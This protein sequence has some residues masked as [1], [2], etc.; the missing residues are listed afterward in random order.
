MLKII[1]SLLSLDLSILKSL[2]N[3]VIPSITPL[4]TI[5]T[6]FDILVF[7]R[8]ELII[9]LTKFYETRPF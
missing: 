4:F 6:G 2:K 7:R 9:V 5:G 1:D 8:I 3:T